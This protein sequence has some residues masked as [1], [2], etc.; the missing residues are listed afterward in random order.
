VGPL[1]P[2]NGS[3]QLILQEQAHPEDLRFFP[4]HLAQEKPVYGFGLT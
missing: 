3:R 2:V 1:L 4:A